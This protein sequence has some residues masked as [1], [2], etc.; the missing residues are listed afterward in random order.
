MKLARFA[1]IMLISSCCAA[2]VFAADTLVQK[3]PHPSCI[4]AP[5][6]ATSAIQ[7]ALNLNANDEVPTS[8]FE[9]SNSYSYNY[10]ASGNLF[11]SLGI[12]HGINLYFS[13]SADN[14]WKTYVYIDGTSIG[15]GVLTFNENG[16]LTSV[17]GMRNLTFTP[18]TGAQSPQIISIDMTCSTQ[19]ANDDTVINYSQ[20][21][22]TEGTSF[23]AVMKLNACPAST[24][25]ATSLVKW[26]INL[27]ANEVTPDTA[28]DPRDAGTYNFKTNINIHD[29]LGA[30]Y[31]LSMYYVKTGVNSWTAYAYMY[32][33][34]LGTGTI[35]FTSNGS[36][37]S[38]EGLD[39]INW[40]PYTGAKS[41]QYFSVD[42]TC[43]TQ[44]GSANKIKEKAWQD[45]HELASS[46][47]KPA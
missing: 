42:M 34:K 46:L 7:W 27:N 28:F 1:K 23:R 38:V 30:P 17:E 47:K 4:F 6:K 19:F 40:Q 41:P 3:S 37:A 45:G 39:N 16:A 12:E 31:R 10:V 43:S 2:P 36:I 33:I 11:D 35:K 44:Y 20:D 25:A 5:V 29:S 22:H 32:L 13:K 24:P 9:P 14:T 18:S 15:T 21:G 26:N 8:P